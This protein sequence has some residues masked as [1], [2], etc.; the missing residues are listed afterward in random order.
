[1]GVETLDVDESLYSI[2]TMINNGTW[3]IIQRFPLHLVRFE[4]LF[5]VLRASPQKNKEKRRCIR[6]VLVISES[7]FVI[8]N[9]SVTLS[10]IGK[11]QIG[12][13]KIWLFS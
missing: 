5:R 9:I 7:Q 1:M 8:F 4:P 11:M 3:Q 6:I 10:V 12:I 2:L 13:V